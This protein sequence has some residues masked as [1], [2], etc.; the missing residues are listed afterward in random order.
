MSFSDSGCVQCSRSVK[1]TERQNL[2]CQAQK[3]SDQVKHKPSG[4][5]SVRGDFPQ[6]TGFGSSVNLAGVESSLGTFIGMSF[7]LPQGGWLPLD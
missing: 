2:L 7:D 3:N 1:S 6:F 4:V 5:I